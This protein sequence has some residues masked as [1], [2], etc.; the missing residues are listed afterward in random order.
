MCMFL[1]CKGTEDV[2]V[3]MLSK[4]IDIF[5][6]YRR[7]TS[8]QLASLLKVMLQLRGYKVFI[9]VDRLCAGKFDASLLKN[10]QAA[11]HF[12]LLLAEHSFD[13]LLDDDACDD[14]IHKEVK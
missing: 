11:N 3:V 2:D 13:R 4:E 6:S 5:I 10:V 8:S 7:S 1:D 12:I 9:D 14:W